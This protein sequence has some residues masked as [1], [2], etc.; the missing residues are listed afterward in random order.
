MSKYCQI[1]AILRCFLSVSFCADGFLSM[2]E[3]LVWFLIRSLELRVV[4]TWGRG[5]LI[6]R[7][8]EI[9]K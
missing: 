2:V 8:R 9:K 3:M 7:H 6:C 5:G 1:S 4:S